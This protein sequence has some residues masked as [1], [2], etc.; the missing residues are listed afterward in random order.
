[1]VMIIHGNGPSVRFLWSARNSLPSRLGGLLTV[2]IIALATSGI[3]V[4][5]QEPELGV[6][7]NTPESTVPD[8]ADGKAIAGKLC[9]GCHLIDK[10]SG[11]ATPADVPSFPSIADRPKQSFDALSNWL[12]APH[13]PMPDPHLT[14]K[15]IR[16]LAGY[17]VSLRTVP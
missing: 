3:S 6:E 17:I 8:L 9:V 5:A 7:P 4:N 13:A 2:A 12:M 10:T 11:G 1:M 15:E 14:R 16:D